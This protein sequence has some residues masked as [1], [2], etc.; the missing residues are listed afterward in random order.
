ML[1]EALSV[2]LGPRLIFC[3][4]YIQRKLK[5]CFSRVQH[6]YASTPLANSQWKSWTVLEV[7][8]FNVVWSWG[9]DQL[10]GFYS[11]IPE[12]P[13]KVWRTSVLFFCFVFFTLF[14]SPQH[15]CTTTHTQMGRLALSLTDLI[16]SEWGLRDQQ[17]VVKHIV[18]VCRAA[19]CGFLHYW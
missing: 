11:S 14:T 9:E 8:Y 1:K 5:R 18:R 19:I 3:I 2:I 17:L 16:W 6:F 12:S 7:L 15:K 10:L 13:R 4:N